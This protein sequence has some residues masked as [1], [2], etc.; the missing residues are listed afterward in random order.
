MPSPLPSAVN[1]S[2]GSSS[3]ANLYSAPSSNLCSAGAA[4]AISGSGPWHWFCNGSYGGTNASCYANLVVNGACG[5]SSGASFYVAPSSNLCSNGSFSSVT[6]S[7][8]WSWFCNGSYGGTNASCSA[9]LAVDGLCGASNGTSTYPA[10][11][12]NFC[13]VGTN[14]A[15][16]GS[17]PWYWF[18]NGSYSGTNASC[19]ASMM[20]QCNASHTLSGCSSSGG[21]PVAA[22]GCVL[23][24]FNASSCTAGWG[25]FQNW[26]TTSAVTSTCTTASHAWANTSVE[27]CTYNGA[28]FV[29]GYGYASLCYMYGA[30]C[31]GVGAYCYCV[32]TVNAAVTQIG[33]G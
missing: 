19:S 23:C 29:N 32:Y 8:P 6:G 28:Q 12:S 33:C 26:S 21:E 18:C 16:T 3:G 30:N 2:C 5:A 27:S 11:S 4:S 7:G 14:S 9:N 25:Q 20:A 15:V 1:G 13:S 24:R 31:V 22:Q 17:G 10:P